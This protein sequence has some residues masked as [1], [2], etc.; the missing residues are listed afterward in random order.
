MGKKAFGCAASQAEIWLTLRSEHD[1]DLA[2][3]Q[4]SVLKTAQD[5]AQTFH[6]DFSHQTQDAFPATENHTRC[7]QRVLSL[8]NAKT[9]DVP[10]RWS[11][12]FG[13]YLQ[14]CAGAY[15]GIGAGKCCAPLHTECYEYPDALLQ[16]T[17]NAF[18]QLIL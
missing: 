15:F 13:Y 3:L 11:E 5:L 9:L 1:N 17:I 7:A 8:T 12:D 6:L 4:A 2:A 18:L 16:P 14:H 10:V